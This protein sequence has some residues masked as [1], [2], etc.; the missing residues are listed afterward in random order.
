MIQEQFELNPEFERFVDKYLRDARIVD[1]QERRAYIE[2]REPAESMVGRK[3]WHSYRVMNYAKELAQS[4]GL[5]QEDVEIASLCGL[6][7]DVGRFPQA[8]SKRSFNDAATMFDHGDEGAMMLESGLA[9]KFITLDM[10]SD[11]KDM[12]VVTAK[13][14]NKLKID[15][16][17]AGR[18]LEFVK[19]VRDADKLDILD[20]QGIRDFEPGLPI[21]E[22]CLEALEKGR[23]VQN[24][25]GENAA[26]RILRCLGFLFDLNYA[27][28]YQIVSKKKFIDKMTGLLIE[29]TF[30]ETTIERLKKIKSKL[31][32]SVS[33]KMRG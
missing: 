4:V 14:H 10:P 31:T 20:K 6:L 11:T 1:A 17:L 19:I 9:D 30:D 5:S 15:D 26:E 18:A 7:H 28:S 33:A 16:G 3:H 22:D 2:G 27:R 8:N 13:Y 24:S 23:P 25:E 21:S 29:R 12:L 32:R